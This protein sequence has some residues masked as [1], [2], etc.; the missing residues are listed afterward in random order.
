MLAY[1][2]P[3]VLNFTIFIIN[4]VEFGNVCVE[5]SAVNTI[6]LVFL[7]LYVLIS[8]VP[9]DRLKGLFVSI[10]MS[11]FLGLENHGI[12][13]ASPLTD[14]YVKIGGVNKANIETPSLV[15]DELISTVYIF[16]ILMFITIYTKKDIKQ[17]ENQIEYW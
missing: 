7:I 9:N 1:V 13:A 3:V 4:Y 6:A 15:I 17:Y 12:L 16:I 5:F 8:L 11:F 2:L 14:C 10:W